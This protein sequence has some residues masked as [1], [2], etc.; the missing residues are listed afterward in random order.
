MA[1]V[2]V[3]D[4]GETKEEG[5]VSGLLLSIYDN[6]NDIADEPSLDG[7][8]S[9]QEA[10]PGNE[11]SLTRPSQQVS[12]ANSSPLDTTHGEQAT[13]ESEVV[14]QARGPVN[15][16]KRRRQVRDVQRGI[17]GLQSMGLELLTRR[18]ENDFIL[19]QK[20]IELQHRKLDNDERRLALEEKK[21]FLFEERLQQLETQC[22]QNNEKMLEQH[23]KKMMT[24][25]I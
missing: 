16:Q 19:R 20:E 5:C 6:N 24:L 25:L 4:G 17:R 10:T 9:P 1:S 14:E 3:S 12:A 22:Q 18:E 15:P 7:P 8:C 2:N 11:G 21:V 23:A 13:E